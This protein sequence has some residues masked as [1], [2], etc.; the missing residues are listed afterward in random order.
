[1]P[2]LAI[3]SWSLHRTLGPT[4]PGLP[5]DDSPRPAEY[6]YGHGSMTLLDLPSAVAARGIRNLEICHFHFPRT[7]LAYLR[8]LRERFD[9]V[10]VTPLTVL[11]DAGDISAADP[12]ARERDLALVRGWIDLAAALGAKQ[13]RVVAGR[14]QPDDTDAAQRS[15][16]GLAALAQYA[17]ARGVRVITENWLALTMHPETLLAILDAAGEGIGLCADFGNYSGPDKYQQLRMIL[18]R[19]TSA[20]TKADFSAPG[21]MDEQDFRRCL[22]LSR[23]AGFTGYHVLIFDGPGD[24]W[25]SIEQMIEIVRPYL[26]PVATTV[27]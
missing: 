22:D 9:S 23:D 10:G 20:H 13:A 16:D 17:E 21:R 25:A 6:P 12:A 3:S 4:Y 5:M 11:I 24:E 18:P 8:Q 1:M 14:A 15:A 19:A 7:D 26:S 2:E 27:S